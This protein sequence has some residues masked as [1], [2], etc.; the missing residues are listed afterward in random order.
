MAPTA[1]PCSTGCLGDQF[2]RNAQGSTMSPLLGEA[3]KRSGKLAQCHIWIWQIRSRDAWD[4]LAY[5]AR[6]STFAALY[7]SCHSAP[8][9]PMK[10][11]EIPRLARIAV[12]RRSRG[13]CTAD[14]GKAL[15]ANLHILLL[16]ML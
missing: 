4:D 11:L 10:T 2:L 1:K 9:K 16:E 3:A 13:K 6:S 15:L 14:Q 8:T 12:C 7:S 5:A